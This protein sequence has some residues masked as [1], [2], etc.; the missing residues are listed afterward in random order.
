MLSLSTARETGSTFNNQEFN[1]PFKSLKYVLLYPTN[2][3]KF[4]STLAIFALT[5]I[6]LLLFLVI[7]S[8]NRYSI[9]SFSRYDA[10]PRNITTFPTIFSDEKEEKTN[11]SH[12]LF[13][14]GGS[15]KTWNDRRHYSELWW[16]PNVTRGF[17]WLDENPETTTS[18]ESFMPYR[19]S[20]DTSDFKYS[21]SYGSRSAV[22][23]ARILKESFELGLENVRWFVMGDD[24]TVFFTEN[25]V[26]VLGKYDHNQMYYVGGNSESVEQNVIH[27]YSMAYGGGGFAVSYPLAAELVRVLDSCINRYHKFFGSD[28]KVQGCLSEIGIPLTRELGFHQLDIRG[29]SYGLLAAHPVAPLVSLHHI[30]HLE[31]LF[32]NQTRIDSLKRLIGAYEMDPGRILQQTVC[33]DLKRNWSIS[34]SWGYT[35]QLYPS[36]VSAKDLTTAWLTFKTWRTWNLGPFTFNTRFFS[37]DPCKNPVFYFMDRVEKTGSDRT[38]TTYKKQALTTSDA[39][40]CEHVDYAAALAIHSFNVSAPHFN[41]ELWNKAPRRQCCEIIND[42]DTTEG[43]TPQLLIRGC[44]QYE[45]VTPN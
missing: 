41:P 29:H 17:V 23:M 3:L 5:F 19:V 16:K 12:I 4:K 22:R 25:L 1:N 20:G 24:D 39:H 6:S 13:G 34:V 31:P 14:I 26:V 44:N 40:Q 10:I 9:I 36:L 15:A 11:I 21:C 30:N 28:Q 33:Y 38:S 7:I 27:S 45:S 18:S 37:Q 8:S 43:G 2:F 35:L 42:G 32:P